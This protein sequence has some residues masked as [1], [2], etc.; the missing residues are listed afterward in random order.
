MVR[1]RKRVVRT[2]TP[3]PSEWTELLRIDGGKGPMITS[4]IPLPAG[5]STSR[6]TRAL[7]GYTVTAATRLT[8]AFV[9][10]AALPFSL[11]FLISCA[12]RIGRSESPDRF[13]ANT[14]S[15]VTPRAT[16]HGVIRLH[17]ARGS[18][19][20]EEVQRRA[21]AAN[22]RF[23]PPSARRRINWLGIIA[24]YETRK[25]GDIAPR[26]RIRRNRRRRYENVIGD[27]EL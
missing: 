19:R 12:V 7:V 2:R 11:A 15:T 23:N 9:A 13:M 8:A 18:F 22:D 4:T 3:S 14:A 17:I 6:V 1:E 20:S 26:S 25:L 5:T 16:I 27:N 21:G 10:G 24:G